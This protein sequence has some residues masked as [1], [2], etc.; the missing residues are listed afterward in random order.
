M[1]RRPWTL[2]ALGR[3]ISVPLTGL[4]MSDLFT[5]ET[6]GEFDAGT[7]SIYYG[8]ITGLHHTGDWQSP[9]HFN[10][11]GVLDVLPY[12]EFPIDLTFDQLQT[13]SD[14]IRVSIGQYL[15][16]TDLSRV[17]FDA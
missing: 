17:K 12:I 15:Y 16:G 6:E 7:A 14:D 4:K 11:E 2:Q 1:C 5:V 13:A 3:L 9:I 10:G 8:S